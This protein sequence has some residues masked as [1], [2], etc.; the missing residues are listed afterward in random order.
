MVNQGTFR[1]GYVEGYR[2]IKGNGIA[3]P[4]SPAAP[5]APAGKT[6][7]QMGLLAGIRAAGG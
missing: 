1:D 7:F 5:A 6:A 3:V 2:A 4:A